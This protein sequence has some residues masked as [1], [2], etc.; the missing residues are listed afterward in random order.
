M[1][2]TPTV[3]QKILA[4]LP[5]ER[6]QGL[7]TLQAQQARE[8][9]SCFTFFWSNPQRSESAAKKSLRFKIETQTLGKS[10][11]TSPAC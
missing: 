6:K 3:K 4:A 5:E 1:N 10:T 9:K 8:R 11:L 7:A 2:D